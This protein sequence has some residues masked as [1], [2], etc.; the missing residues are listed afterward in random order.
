ME[1]IY[2][3]VILYYIIFGLL[4]FANYKVYGNN[5]RKNIFYHVIKE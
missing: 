4:L 2:I 3:I 5:Q 1:T